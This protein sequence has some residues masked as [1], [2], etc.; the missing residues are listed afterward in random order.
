V[1]C[2]GTPADALADAARIERARDGER[3]R[4]ALRAEHERQAREP[5]APLEPWE[6]ASAPDTLPDEI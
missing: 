3:F 6:R 2:D 4:A 1:W 5:R